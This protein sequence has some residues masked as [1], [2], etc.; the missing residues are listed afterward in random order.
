ML[1]YFTFKKVKQHQAEKKGKEALAQ[2]KTPPP[3]I[4]EDD[5]RFLERIVSA[6]GT[7]PPLP[8]RPTSALGPE[9]GDSTGNN[10]QLIVPEAQ[11]AKERRSSEQK[12]KGKEHRRS[13]EQKDKGKGKEKEK[14]K[15]GE[16]AKKS[17][18]F[19]FIQR[20]FTKKVILRSPP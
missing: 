20:T 2:V 9:A 3:L 7:P 8:S 15:S 11:E 12:N 18:R 1:E 10:S 6:E 13:S 16:D 5:E 14:E 19:S 4:D 17:N